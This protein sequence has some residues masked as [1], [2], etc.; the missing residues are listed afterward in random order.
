MIGYLWNE[1]EQWQ[2]VYNMENITRE[3]ELL[4][5]LDRFIFVVAAIALGLLVGAYFATPFIFGDPLKTFLQAIITNL[6]PVLLLFLLSYVAYR[7]IQYIRS[8]HETDLFAKKVSDNVINEL[9]FGKGVRFLEHFS[10][11][12][13]DDFESASDLWIVG[14]SLART[15][16]N[17]YSLMESKLRKGHSIHILLV[18]PNG[19]ASEVAASRPYPSTDVAQVRRQIQESLGYLSKL[20]AIK[21]DKLQVRTIE[22]PL[23]RGFTAINPDTTSGVLYIEEYAYQTI[24]NALPRFILRAKDGGWYDFFKSE[25]ENLWNSGTDWAP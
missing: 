2:K 8:Q 23:I 19:S 20:K 15:I 13:Q 18:H 10:P 4:N 14:V 1:G 16:R 9:E 11:S 25:L 17:N 22:N 5:A 24:G 12:L 7:R 3:Q 21:P 6:I